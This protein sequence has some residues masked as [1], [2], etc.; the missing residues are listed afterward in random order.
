MNDKFEIRASNFPYDM[1]SWC[2]EKS[3]NIVTEV[4]RI[5]DLLTKQ[6]DLPNAFR[7]DLIYALN[8]IS[9][10][11]T[12]LL[13][14]SNGKEWMPKDSYLINEK[15]YDG[16]EAVAVKYN[17]LEETTRDKEKKQLRLFVNKFNNYLYGM[18]APNRTFIHEL[19]L[20]CKINHSIISELTDLTEKVTMGELT[21]DSY[22]EKA[23][24]R[25]KRFE[26][27][28]NDSE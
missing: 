25:L 2:S 6:N 7:E 19:L 3:E 22:V 16:Y 17:L 21:W 8:C 1:S 24:L 28:I 15:G 20:G 10:D 13:A 14:F 4:A 5:F 23:R 11:S 9:W 27:L 26:G 12:K 18:R